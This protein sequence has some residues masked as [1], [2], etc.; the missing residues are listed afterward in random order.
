MGQ[1]KRVSN[2][3][4][5][6]IPLLHFGQFRKRAFATKHVSD[7][8]VLLV[9]GRLTHCFLDD[10]AS[11]DLLVLVHLLGWGE[12]I[13]SSIGLPPETGT[14]QRTIW[15]GDPTNILPSATTKVR[16]ETISQ[17]SCIPGTSP[18]HTPHSDT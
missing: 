7:I 9:A 6:D 4:N 8:V 18:L 16:K 3:G 12:D 1:R 10:M 17:A 13:V 14:H 15:V 11:I 2:R 5:Q